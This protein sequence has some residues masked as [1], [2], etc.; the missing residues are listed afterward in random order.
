LKPEKVAN[1]SD[2][3]NYDTDDENETVCEDRDDNDNLGDNTSEHM[4][5]NSY[6]WCLMRFAIVKYLLNNITQFLNLIG[7]EPQGK[8]SETRGFS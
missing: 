6:S 2:V 1:V 4:D 3:V 5:P 8:I 7:I